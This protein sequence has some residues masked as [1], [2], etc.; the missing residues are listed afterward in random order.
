MVCIF[1]NMFVMCLDH[2]GQSE[3]FETML[4]Y[5]N[6]TFIAIFTIEFIMKVIALNYRYFKIGL[7]IF[8]FVILIFS[9]IGLPFEN[10]IKNYLSISPTLLRVIRLARFGRVLRLFKAT[11]GIRTIL[12]ALITSLPAL[13]NIGLLLFLIIFIYAIFGMNFFKNVGYS[14]SGVTKEFNFENIYRCIITLFPLCTSGGWSVLLDAISHEGPP[15]CNPNITSN[16]S[17]LTKGD[18]GSKAL[19]IPFLV[20]FVVVTFFIIINMYIAI[21]LD[22]FSEAKEDVQKGLTDDDF[23]LYYEVWQRFDPHRTEYIKYAEL[24]DFVDSL[25]EKAAINPCNSTEENNILYESPLRIPK[26]NEEKI[27]SMDIIICE[28][29]QVN[30]ED[31]LEALKKNYFGNDEVIESVIKKKKRPENYYPISSTSKKNHNN[32]SK[33]TSILP[34]SNAAL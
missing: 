31:I 18:C 21:I 8:D 1:L 28:N 4:V 20:S 5:L 22:N 16:S 32:S 34:E 12:F 19:A 14:N 10:F 27:I 29:Y 2:Y 33:V 26:P 9:I 25:Y 30:C 13:L 23:D 15:F 24:S 7:N 3:K 17:E 6:Y 11:K